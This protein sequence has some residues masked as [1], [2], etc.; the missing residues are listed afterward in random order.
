MRKE[1]IFGLLLALGSGPALAQEDNSQAFTDWDADQSGYID[2]EEF[3]TGIGE[4]DYFGAWDENEDDQITE[5]EF[6]TVGFD[7]WD[8]DDSGFIDEQEYNAGLFDT[9]DSDN[10]DYLDY[11]E[12]DDAGDEGWFDV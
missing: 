2:D 11:S 6:G 7:N 12:W 5:D 3:G 4:N 8:A 10:T 9:W 1:I